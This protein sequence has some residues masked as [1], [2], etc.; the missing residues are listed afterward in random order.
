MKLILNFYNFI[1]IQP[2]L[3]IPAV[4]FLN[5]S[6]IKVCGVPSEVLHIRNSEDFTLNGKLIWIARM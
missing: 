5:S 4:I 2:L 1:P 3:V 6:L